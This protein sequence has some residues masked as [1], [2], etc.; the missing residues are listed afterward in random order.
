MDSQRSVVPGAAF[1][2][3]RDDI[4]LLRFLRRGPLGLSELA[5]LS[6]F[7]RN[8]VVARI[9]RLV[10]RD[11]V[12]KA[13]SGTAERG[14]PS[15]R[16][17]L[18]ARV[19]LIYV[20]A[21]EE[22]RVLASICDLSGAPLASMTRELDD[23][24]H[25]DLAV[26]HVVEML[27]RLSGDGAVDRDRIG[28]CVMSVQGPVSDK[29]QT[30]PWSRVGILPTDLDRLIGMTTLVENDANLMAVGAVGSFATEND[31]L[32]ILVA[33]GI[34]AGVIVHGQL[35]R[36]ASGWAGEV[37]HVAIPA[38]GDRPCVCGSRGCASG[39]AGNFALF[40]MM[41]EAG[42]TVN[43]IEELEQLAAEGNLD[44]V[45]A[46]RTV[47]R[48]IG[49]AILGLTVGLAP[50]RIVVGGQAAQ[51]GDHLVAGIRETLLQKAPAALSHRVEVHIEPD[52]EAA[53]RSGASVSG[54]DW[55]FPLARS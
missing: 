13:P 44:A 1:D 23:D 26:H 17:Q 5:E 15:A 31:T 30:V 38:G 47:G 29:R 45:I 54:F 24:Y 21:F 16:F 42:H 22:H 37:G 36:D 25:P 6:G 27:E 19:A 50:S 12:E 48:H 20:V 2:L 14:R 33:N 8:T 28:L 43:T 52:H 53:I 7:A 18:N 4:R 10:P 11:L 35:V 51:I 41:R 32:C 39:V 34:G 55:M 3:E 40:D 49:E 46:L 9:N